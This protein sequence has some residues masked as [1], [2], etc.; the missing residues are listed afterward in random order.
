MHPLASTRIV[1]YLSLFPACEIIR[2][3]VGLPDGGLESAAHED[4]PD[5]RRNSCEPPYL[6][7]ATS[8]YFRRAAAPLLWNGSEG[9]GRGAR[10]VAAD[11]HVIWPV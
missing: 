3:A 11:M 6:C 7:R 9:A 8:P 4:I 1:H 2:A 5:R 10:F